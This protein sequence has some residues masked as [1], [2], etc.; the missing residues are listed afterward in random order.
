MDIRHILEVYNPKRLGR[1]IFICLSKFCILPAI[2]ANL[3][4]LGGVDIRGKCWIYSNVTIDTVAPDRIHIEK[5]VTITEGV[6]I[7]THYLD[8]NQQ[9][10]RYRLGDVHIGKGTFIGVGSIICN[11]VRIGQNSIIGAGS[12]VTKDIPDN[13][14]WAGN[15]A[16]YIKDRKV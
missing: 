9:G 15:P 6:K 10:R 13:Q 12:V 14:V 8:P 4:K 16:R 1:M 3:L 2:R 11:S 5:E 7:L